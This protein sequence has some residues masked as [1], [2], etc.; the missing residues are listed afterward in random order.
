MKRRYLVAWVEQGTNR[1]ES[2]T[3][4]IGAQKFAMF[5]LARGFFPRTAEVEQRV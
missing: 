3:T 5:V 4:S 2:F 1:I